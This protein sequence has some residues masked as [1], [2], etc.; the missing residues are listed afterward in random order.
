MKSIYFIRHGE[1]V[2]NAQ[3]LLA[4]STDTPLTDTGR[5]QARL[6]GQQAKE[7][8]I[9]L[10]YASPLSRARETAEIMAREMGHPPDQIV[11]DERLVERHFG[12]LEGTVWEFGIDLSG[13]VDLETI[14][15]LHNRVASIMTE[16]QERAEETILI[17]S[18]GATGRMIREV[19]DYTHAYT[20]NNTTV[21]S[22][23]AQ[24]MKVL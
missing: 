1:S 21:K 13:A 19:L 9:T 11:F 24:L 16:I 14:A 10:I 4:G 12:S 7:L 20:F 15:H 22:N 17:V 5:E 18:H 23:N 8:G 2:M 6:A 3:G